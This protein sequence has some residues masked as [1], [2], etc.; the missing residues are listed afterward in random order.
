MDVGEPATKRMSKASARK[1]RR[2]QR[3]RDAREKVRRLG[4]D[5]Y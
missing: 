4:L 1:R 5:I 2:A 3:Q